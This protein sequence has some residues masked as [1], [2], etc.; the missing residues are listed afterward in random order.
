MFRKNTQ[1]PHDKMHVLN[2]YFVP[3]AKYTLASL[4][5]KT[6]Q[7]DTVSLFSF[8]VKETDSEGKNQLPKKLS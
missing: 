3:V 5:L 8:S 6:S 7:R 2:V 1:Y 4:I